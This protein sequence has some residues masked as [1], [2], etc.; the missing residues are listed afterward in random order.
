MCTAHL[1]SFLDFGL[2]FKDLGKEG[3][4]HLL[5]SLLDVPGSGVEEL[6]GPRGRTQ[7]CLA[8]WV[9]LSTEGRAPPLRY[10]QLLSSRFLIQELRHLLTLG[11]CLATRESHSPSTCHPPPAMGQDLEARE[12]M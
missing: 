3:E 10:P 5:E 1:G 12:S 6:L 4:G 11:V 2:H 7:P 9:V 8:S